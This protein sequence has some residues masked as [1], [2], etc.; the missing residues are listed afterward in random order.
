MRPTGLPPR[1]A[2]SGFTTSASSPWL[3]AAAVPAL[4]A[5]GHPL[6]FVTVAIVH[7][8][9]VVTVVRGAG[10]P[11]LVPCVTGA[12]RSMAAHAAA[13]APEEEPHDAE[14]QQ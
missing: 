12:M 7:S 6:L 2:D 4:T 5:R 14:S 13:S 10:A 9:I 8:G 1:H 3:S 11:S